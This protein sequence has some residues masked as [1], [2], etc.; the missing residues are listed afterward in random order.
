MWRILECPKL[1]WNF[2]SSSYISFCLNGWGFYRLGILFAAFHLPSSYY[3]RCAF[4]IPWCHWTLDFTHSIYM[5]FPSLCARVNLFRLISIIA[6]FPTSAFNIGCPDND[7]NKIVVFAAG[8]HNLYMKLRVH[9]WRTFCVV[10][11]MPT[12]G[13]DQ[14]KAR[15]PRLFFMPVVSCFRLAC[16]RMK[17]FV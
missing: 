6:K 5:T 9:A 3:S 12:L 13:S 14:I 7:L 2:V 4:K 15:V 16:K 1:D 11:T 8:I 10:S 17:V